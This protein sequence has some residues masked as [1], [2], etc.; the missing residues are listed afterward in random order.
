MER[1]PDEALRQRAMDQCR[2]HLESLIDSDLVFFE[3][4]PETEWDP[5]L[6]RWV[7]AQAISVWRSFGEVEVVVSE[8]GEVVRFYDRNRFEGAR[9]EPI[10]PEELLVIARTTGAV[11]SGA[12][13]ELVREGERG[14]L[15]VEFSQRS[16]GLAERVMV[17]INPSRRLV[18][19]FEIFR[20]G[21]DDR[22]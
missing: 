12:V 4:D 19:A 16:S 20:D 6:H 21:R 14:M 9:F 13:I 5:I 11:K 17:T 15:V 10:D 8:E 18:A 1:M 2:G 3:K 22:G 7:F